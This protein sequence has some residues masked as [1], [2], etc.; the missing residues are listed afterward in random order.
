MKK[1]LIFISLFTFACENADNNEPNVE[2]GDIVIVFP[3]DNDTIAGLTY[4][5][6]KFD[7]ASNYSLL[8]DNDTVYTGKDDSLVLNTPEGVH[9]FIAKYNKN[10]DTVNVYG[11]S[12]IPELIYPENGD[13]TNGK[14]IIKSLTKAASYTIELSEDENFS[15]I[16]L[17][18]TSSDTT[19]TF[20]L[21][22]LKKGY[23]RVYATNILGFKGNYSNHSLF[24]LTNAD[25]GDTNTPFHPVDT[26]Y[27]GPKDDEAYDMERDGNNF[28]ICGYTSSRG[29]GGKDIYLITVD[30]YGSI[31]YENTYG[32]ANDE[33]GFTLDISSG[34]YVIGGYKDNG[35][36]KFPYILKL[37]TNTKIWDKSL[38]IEGGE[39]R[40][41]TFF[42]NKYFFAGRTLDEKAFFGA[43]DKNGKEIFT[44]TIADAA[45]YTL[46]ILNNNIFL[47][48]Y[49]KD[50]VNKAYIVKTDLSGN[51]KKEIT[52]SEG[53]S[54]IYDINSYNG[55]LYFTG[56]NSGSGYS[57]VYVLSTNEEFSP[58]SSKEIGGLMGEDWGFK[59]D[60]YNGFLYISGFTQSY[61]AGLYDVYLLKLSPSLELKYEWYTGGSESEWG[62]ALKVNNYGIAITGMTNSK[63]AGIRDV[64]F[65]L[66]KDN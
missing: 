61:G 29:A 17:S 12:F 54:T 5:K 38:N 24:Y 51:I 53:R 15:N 14:F 59:I 23:W 16:D 18:K 26:T 1:I 37:S 65:I 27:G 55:M 13:S 2:K 64:L 58:I 11:L 21:T 42:D 46:E 10:F 19:F 25:S 6:V 32:E 3:K 63:G 39:I 43:T 20:D 41:I 4:I 48:G 47:A 33:I 31:I 22:N 40:D 9:K 66:K 62:Y 34:F 60:I 7:K 8:L 30:K 44:K 57:D 28:I 35:T 49:K 56:Y 50:N 36:E 52:P 45:F